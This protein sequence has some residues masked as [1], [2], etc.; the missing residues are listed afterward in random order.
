M[1]SPYILHGIEKQSVIFNRPYLTEDREMSFHY[2]NAFTNFP[3]ASFVVNEEKKHLAIQEQGKSRKVFIRLNG[4]EDFLSV[5]QREKEEILELLREYTKRLQLGKEIVIVR[6]TGLSDYPYFFTTETIENH[7]HRSSKFVT[8]FFYFINQ[9][10]KESGAGISLHDFDE[11][12]IQLG[13]LFNRESVRIKSKERDG[14]QEMSI[15]FGTFRS[16]LKKKQG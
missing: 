3:S 15:S 9:Q 7:G 4:N 16:K 14:M 8:G 1:T 12:Q 6:E 5:V 13:K 11:A 2:C 10:L